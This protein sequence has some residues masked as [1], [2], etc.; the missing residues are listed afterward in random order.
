MHTMLI[1]QSVLN[2]KPVS[3]VIRQS[4][5]SDISP[6]MQSTYSDVASDCDGE[7]SSEPVGSV[8]DDVIASS[9]MDPLHGDADQDINGGNVT[10][11]VL[12]P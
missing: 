4:P 6:P 3:D 11:L 2:R 7:V 9:A 12:S 5:D 10:K 1:Q 8:D